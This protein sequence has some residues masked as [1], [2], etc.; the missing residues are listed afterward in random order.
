MYAY[1]RN[2][3]ATLNDPT[4]L[5][6]ADPV[7][8]I[9]GYPEGRSCKKT[10]ECPKQ[11]DNPG[12]QVT[13]AVKAQSPD[14]NLPVNYNFRMVVINDTGGSSKDLDRAYDTR[15]VN[16]SLHTAPDANNP[17]GKPVQGSDIEISEHLSNKTLTESAV[18]DSVF[19][20]AIGP[21]GARGRAD[22]ATDRYFTVKMGG[23]ELGVIPILDRFGT[24]T[25]DHIVIEY[26]KDRVKLNGT[27]KPT[28]VPDVR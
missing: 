13:P 18:K 16:C 9:H 1:V 3:P 19:R 20:D 24:H 2:N 26:L 10:Y 21:Q 15:D 5:L 22:K 7:T 11:T 4:G 27:Y 25:Q 8:E 12:P 28:D 23:K 17:T 14:A 6:G